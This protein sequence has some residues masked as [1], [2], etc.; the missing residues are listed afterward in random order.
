MSLETRNPSCQIKSQGRGTGNESA[1]S[2]S[3]RSRQPIVANR[4][5]PRPITSHNSA[6]DHGGS[7]ASGHRS[8]LRP[9]LTPLQSRFI[10]TIVAARRI[11]R[12]SQGKRDV[13]RFYTEDA[14][15]FRTSSFVKCR[16]VFFVFFSHFHVS[17]APHPLVQA[18]EHLI[19]AHSFKVL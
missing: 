2:K 15:N 4:T 12:Y 17:K 14:H 11:E 10:T 9:A 19:I 3:A 16:H 7:R 6:T 1:P 13:A 5:I 8:V 18:S